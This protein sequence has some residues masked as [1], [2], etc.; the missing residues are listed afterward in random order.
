M[1]ARLF[2]TKRILQCKI[3]EFDKGNFS[4]FFTT[5]SAASCPSVLVHTSVPFGLANLDSDM[6]EIENTIYGHFRELFPSL[7]RPTSTRCIRWR[8]SQV[9]K[10]FPGQPGAAVASSDPL[11]VL[12]GDAFVHSNFSGCVE[13]ANAVLGKICEHI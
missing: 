4:S 9:Y 5:D 2:Q 12:A 7:P 11:L 6:K 13:S 3:H 1:S 10:S 8:Y